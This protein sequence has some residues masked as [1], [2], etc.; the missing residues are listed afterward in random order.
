MQDMNRSSTAEHLRGTT[1]YP[2]FQ[3]NAGKKNQGKNN[4]FLKI[5]NSPLW[6]NQ[7]SNR[8]A[9]V[10]AESEIYSCMRVRVHGLVHSEWWGCFQDVFTAFRVMDKNHDG[11]ISRQGFRNLHDSLMF[12]TKE[13]EYSR[14]LDLLG[15]RPGATLNYAEFNSMVQAG[16]GTAAFPHPATR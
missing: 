4:D 1:L 3:K 16:A 15:L 7:A 12:V 13:T 2:C 8:A 5:N 10:F 14:L 6:L 9:Q 11:V